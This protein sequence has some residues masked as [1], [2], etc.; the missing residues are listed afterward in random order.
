MYILTDLTKIIALL[1]N[2][3]SNSLVEKFL[4]F[5][6]AAASIIRTECR[7]ERD[8]SNLGLYGMRSTGKLIPVY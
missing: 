6:E 8:S 4:R 2:V 1:W 7:K 3:T 5:K